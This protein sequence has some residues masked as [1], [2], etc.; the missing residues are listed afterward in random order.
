MNK[1]YIIQF[2]LDFE[3]TLERI[4]DELK[5]FFNGLRDIN[6][7][8]LEIFKQACKRFGIRSQQST[9]LMQLINQDL[10]IEIQEE[11]TIEQQIRELFSYLGFVESLGNCYVDVL[12]MFLVANGR[13]F[14]IESNYSTPRIRHAVSITDLEKDW[15]PLK[16]KLNFLRENGIETF[17]SLIDTTLRNDI[18]HLNFSIIDGKICTKKHPINK[19]IKPIIWKLILSISRVGMLLNSFAIDM[20]WEKVDYRIEK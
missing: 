12:V 16:T 10:L 19:T 11:P 6:K 3:P 9:K 14:H 2:A 17:T 5:P 13:D 7:S 1:D 4:D 20:G 15:V 8:Q 18:A